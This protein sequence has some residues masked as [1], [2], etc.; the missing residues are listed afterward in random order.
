MDL[1][2][3]AAEKAAAVLVLCNKF[4]SDP[5]MYDVL[6]IM[7]DSNSDPCMYHH[8]CII[9]VAPVCMISEIRTR[10]VVMKMVMVIVGG[11]SPHCF[12]E[13]T[14]RLVSLTV[15]NLILIES[16]SV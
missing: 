10:T 3:V 13:I 4:S 9:I 15:G 7:H 11:T 2:R 1:Q 14:A 6:Y 12:D 16:S 8:R 5:C